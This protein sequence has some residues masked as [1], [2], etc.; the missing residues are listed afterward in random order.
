[1][2]RIVAVRNGDMTEIVKIAVDIGIRWQDAG[3]HDVTQH[4]HAA[5]LGQ[6]H[7]LA[8]GVDVSAGMNDLVDAIAP[9][10]QILK[11]EVQL[12]HGAVDILEYGAGGT[13]WPAAARHQWI[14]L[15]EV[16]LRDRLA[17]IVEALHPTQSVAQTLAIVSVTRDMKGA[18]T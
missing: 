11:I 7:S 12:I 16:S 3:L 4:I 6:R 17:P 5:E 2:I 1:M 14:Q 15:G 8:T 18:I 10:L 9:S 13:S